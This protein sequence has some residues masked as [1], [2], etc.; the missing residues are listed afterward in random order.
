MSLV[1]LY[2]VLAQATLTSFSGFGSLAQVRRDLVVERRVLSDEGLNR[3]VLVARS[4]PGPYGAYVVSV[5]YQ[6]AGIG[7]AVAGWLALTTP[8][9]LAVPVLLG[10]R[11]LMEHPRVRGAVDAL[12]L[13]SALLVVLTGITLARDLLQQIG[14]GG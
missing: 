9:L 1:T 8:A 10:V 12:I 11:R 5:G 7:G 3:S 14:L 4:L 13:A 6:V 2:L